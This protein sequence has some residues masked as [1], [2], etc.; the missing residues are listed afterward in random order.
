VYAPSGVEMFQKLFFCSVT[1]M[2][3]TNKLECLV[4]ARRFG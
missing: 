3:H 4:W 1:V 2:L